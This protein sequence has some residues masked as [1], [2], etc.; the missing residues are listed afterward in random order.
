MSVYH[1]PKPPQEKNAFTNW[2]SYLVKWCTSERVI[3]IQGFTVKQDATG[4]YFA[5]PNSIPQS[6]GILY[7]DPIELDPSFPVPAK[8]LVYIS[9]LNPLVTVGLIDLT[10]GVL[11]TASPGTWYSKKSVPAQITVSGFVK[12]HVPQKLIQATPTGTPLKGDAD[13]DAV[14]W[15]PVGGVLNCR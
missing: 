6:T 14:Y 3:E 15:L 12:Y 7:K 4:K 1:P 9:P 11:V 10:T 8:K 13:S 2:I 5:P